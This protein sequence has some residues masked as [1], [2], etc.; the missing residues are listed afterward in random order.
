MILNTDHIFFLLFGLAFYGDY[1]YFCCYFLVGWLFFSIYEDYFF[2]VSAT[3]EAEG[4]V[5][6]FT[7][8]YS[9]VFDLS[10]LFL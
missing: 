4:S 9:E 1:F 2:N 7:V 8:F 3:L 10:D 5:F 6:N